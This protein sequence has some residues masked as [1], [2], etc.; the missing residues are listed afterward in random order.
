MKKLLLLLL[1]IP[2]NSFFIHFLRSSVREDHCTAL[3]GVQFNHYLKRDEL[4]VFASVGSNRVSVYRCLK[5]GSMDL[6]Q[7]YADPDV[8]SFLLNM[9]FY[10]LLSL[11]KCKMSCSIGCRN[12]LHMLLDNDRIRFK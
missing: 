3:F 12:F 7:C 1:Y 2:I 8:R 10:R 6:V 5:N 9:E 4:P 11:Q